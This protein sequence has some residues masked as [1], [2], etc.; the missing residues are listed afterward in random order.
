MST[1]SISVV[2]PTLNEEINL[3]SCL[4]S[5]KGWAQEII[6]V[7]S[8]SEDATR[9]IAKSFGATVYEHAY[10]NA[11]EQWEWILNS[12]DFS[13]EWIL[14][15]DA[16]SVVTPELRTSISA[17]LSGTTDKSGFYVRHKQMFRGRFIR[18]GGI[19]PRYRLYLFCRDK[20]QVDPHA[21]VDHRF[22][23][24][25]KTGR[26]E[27]DIIENNKKDSLIGPWMSKQVALAERAAQEELN[28]RHD[29]KSENAALLRGRNER[30]LWLKR[31]WLRLPRYWRSV[32]YFLYRYV[33]RLGFLDGREGFLYHFT[34]A[35]TFRIM[36]DARLEELE[37]E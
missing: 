16:D 10:S 28:R 7:D 31:R 17:E 37:R 2:V 19:Y 18:H 32:G 4:E 15:L 11:P 29:R 26:L 14:A 30:V 1:V 25:G 22:F 12:I 27:H 8:G 9:D 23:V 20:V 3:E 13:S 24:R 35:L 6:L 21:L 5:V 33:L 36:L 34:Q